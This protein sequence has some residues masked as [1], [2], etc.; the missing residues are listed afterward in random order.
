MQIDWLHFTPFSA[1]LGGA[2]I[3]LSVALLWQG[4]G[5]IAGM[6]GILAGLMQ[7]L[8]K[9]NQQEWMWRL[10]FITGLVFAPWLYALFAPL[11]PVLIAAQ[12]PAIVIAGLIV[13]IGTRLGSGCTSGHGVCGLARFSLRSL[14][15][16]L[17]FMSAGFITV[18]LL[19]QLGI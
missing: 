11:P 12:W 14:V 16:T 6:S 8:L 13:G 7:G 1:L 2:L 18:F 4:L 17:C 15:A 5:R 19:R 9:R 10:A 3:A